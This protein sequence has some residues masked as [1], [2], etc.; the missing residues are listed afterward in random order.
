MILSS[1]KVEKIPF[2][3][4][5]LKENKI[6]LAYIITVGLFLLGGLI[7]PGFL[8]V[9]HLVNILSL[10]SFL[11]LVVLAQTLVILS[12]GEGID[13]SVGSFISLATVITSQLLNGSDQWLIPKIL[14]VLSIGFLLGLVNGSGIAFFKIPPLVMT[15]AMGSVIQ[16]IGLIYTQGQPKGKASP[17]LI[18]LGTGRFLGIPKILFLWILILLIA[19]VVLE[20][21]RMGKILYG[22]GENSI[23]AEL[24]GI[25][26]KWVRFLTYGFSGMI[27]AFA[28]I[29]LL[30]YTGTS[31]L[32]LG[33]A[34]MMPSVAAAVIGGISLA[35]GNGSYLG[36][37]AGA[38]ILTTLN[39]IMISLK[40][41]EGGRQIVYGIV[42]L[43][44]LFLYSKRE[45]R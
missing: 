17:L 9:N 11:G 36:A 15:L 27:A 38:I 12:G 33:S 21:M 40:A 14:V 45:K 4:K 5:D 16:G 25:K 30:G 10:S 26:T 22:V 42:I 29:C 39:S 13:L 32:D 37:V 19:L 20:R 34:Y 7:N 41:G 6:T 24:C 3:P 2:N 18:S 31:Y 28:G 23:T 1:I 8:H 35:G 44:V 43:L